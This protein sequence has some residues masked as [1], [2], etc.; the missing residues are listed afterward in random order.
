MPFVFSLVLV[1][2]LAE[3]GVVLDNML[4]GMYEYIHPMQDCCVEFQILNRHL[5]IGYAQSTA[6][7]F[8]IHCASRH[9]CD[10]QGC[11]HT[12]SMGLESPW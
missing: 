5:H 1:F 11:L 4:R 2:Y 10:L 6:G 7:A 9:C 8:V 3:M 12:Q